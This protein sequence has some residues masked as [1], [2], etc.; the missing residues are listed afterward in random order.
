MHSGRIAILHVQ[1]GGVQVP[2][3]D[4]PTRAAT[5]AR[6]LRVLLRAH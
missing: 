5:A 2:S 3:R 4:D 6:A 1:Y